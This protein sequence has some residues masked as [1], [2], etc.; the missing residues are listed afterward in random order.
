MLAHVYLCYACGSVHEP[1]ER[2]FFRAYAE[3]EA[4]EK[5]HTD[6]HHSVALL[7]DSQIIFNTDDFLLLQLFCSFECLKV[8]KLFCT[9]H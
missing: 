6:P 8:V 3:H 7:F 5:L 1:M 2:T 9:L 4:H